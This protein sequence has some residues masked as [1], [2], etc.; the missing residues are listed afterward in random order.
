MRIHFSLWWIVFFLLSL[1][2]H[3]LQTYLIVFL[4]LFAHEFGHI[5]CAYRLG[6]DIKSVTIYPFGCGACIENIDHGNLWEEFLIIFC[7]ISMHLI[8]P[9]IFRVL[10]EFDVL[11]SVYYDYLMMMNRS[12]FLFNMLPIFPLDGGR[13]LD[14]FFHL[15]FVYSRA[16]MCT[17]ITSFLILCAVYMSGLIS[18]FSGLMV[19]V[20]LFIQM[21]AMLKD[22][23]YDRL[24]FYWYR[25]THPIDRGVKVH[26]KMD[27][28]RQRA[29]VLLVEHEILDEKLW[30]KR[31][32][33][34]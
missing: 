21:G 30:L 24:A 18:G 6:Y 22:A 27:L 5:L 13:I 19:V 14:C 9:L 7:G 2:S 28:Y 34:G 12:I 3:Q 33:N 1:F 8:Y 16:R 11:S 26:K 25:Y 20:F 15:F 10:L 23:R 32:F 4:M 29:S 17:I 31:K